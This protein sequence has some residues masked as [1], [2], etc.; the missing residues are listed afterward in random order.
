MNERYRL[1][2]TRHTEM[3]CTVL[4]RAPGD[5]PIGTGLPPSTLRAFWIK[6]HHLPLDALSDLPLSLA[7]DVFQHPLFERGRLCVIR[8]LLGTLRDLP[9]LHVVQLPISER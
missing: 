1:C 3:R 5:P 9:R 8:E 2:R 6:A 7:V 4:E